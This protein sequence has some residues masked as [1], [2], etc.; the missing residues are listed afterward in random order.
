[1]L[2]NIL[3]AIEDHRM[4]THETTNQILNATQRGTNN[5]NDA[6][7]AVQPQQQEP[8]EQHVDD[9]AAH[10]M[11]DNT[12]L[13]MR[14]NMTATDQLT[15][16]PAVEVGAQ[17]KNGNYLVS[18]LLEKQVTQG[19]LL[20]RGEDGNRSELMSQIWNAEYPREA[21]DARTVGKYAA[22][23][24]IIHLTM[25][26]DD[27]QYIKNMS[28]AHNNHNSDELIDFHMKI[29]KIVDDSFA[30]MR[31]FDNKKERTKTIGALGDRAYKFFKTEQGQ[32][33]DPSMNHTNQ[34]TMTA[35]FAP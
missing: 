16:V 25:D 14:G 28:I 26:A 29:L 15:F 33:I 2:Q 20:K 23:M 7:N 10:R 5:A 3:S 22:C 24:K 27:R 9:N 6:H 8:Q 34:L 4:Q 30:K 31:S 17:A 21:V 19:L 35:F 12:L 13:A 11:V 32:A 18:D 1:M